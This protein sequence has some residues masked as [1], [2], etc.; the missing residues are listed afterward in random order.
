MTVA[1]TT[2]ASSLNE[3]ARKVAQNLGLSF[4]PTLDTS[5]TLY[6]VL[7]PYR[8][9]LQ[10]SGS[11]APG[12]NYVN[13]VGGALGHRVRF[14]G[15]RQLIGRAIGV[16]SKKTLRVFD[17]T[18]GWGRDACVLA[19]MGC[20]VLMLESSPIMAVLLRDGLKR[21]IQDIDFAQLK[22]RLLEVDS[23]YYLQTLS[24]LE[25]PDVIYIDPMFPPLKKT[26]AVKKDLYLLR[27]LVDKN[28]DNLALFH[29]AC[30]IA[31][32]RVVIK[33]HRHLHTIDSLKPDLVFSGKTI[34]FDVY[35]MR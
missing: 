5:F 32:K 3:I 34:R 11:N 21:A 6:L 2:T 10:A 19:Y 14:G 22:L 29:L 24:Q 28:H 16:S 17:V 33:R 27:Q 8:W 12:P 25:Y 4:V 1:V 31:K 9:Q 30:K 35:L 20:D 18:A 26:A 7:T 23:L 15:I 13:F